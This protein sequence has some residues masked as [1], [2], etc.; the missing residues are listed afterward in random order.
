M[1]T[2]SVQ[3]FF[4][5][6]HKA[7]T[8]FGNVLTTLNDR[9]RG[10]PLKGDDFDFAITIAVAANVAAHLITG[11][12]DSDADPK[13]RKNISES[14]ESYAKERFIEHAKKV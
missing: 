4:N 6:D 7:K 14:Y 3:E 10:R 8:V 11:N 9:K 2:S 13:A 5:S 12:P 1:S